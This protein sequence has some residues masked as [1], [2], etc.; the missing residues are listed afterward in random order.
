MKLSTFESLKLTPDDLRSKFEY[1][2]KTRRRPKDDKIKEFIELTRDRI[3]EGRRQNLS[4]FRMWWAM[5]TAYDVP[6]KQTTYSHVSTFVERVMNS[7]AQPSEILKMAKEWGIASFIKET[8]NDGKK[9]KPRVDLPVFF[10]IFIPLVRAY[11]H[12]RWAKLFNDRNVFPLLKFEPL[13]NTEVNRLR[14]EV[15]TDLI[16]AMGQ[17]LGYRSTLKQWI[18]NMLHYGTAI[19]FPVEDWYREYGVGDDLS[20]VVVKQ[21]L[22]YSIP[23]PSRVFY[24]QFHR[25]GTVNF[26]SGIQFGGYW[27]IVRYGEIKANESYWNRDWISMMDHDLI[28]SNGTFFSTVYPCQMSFPVDGKIGPRS[29]A[30]ELD[31]ESNASFYTSQHSDKGVVLCDLYQKL[32]PFQV[33][34]TSDERA[35]F[36][37]WFRTVVANDVDVVYMA[38]LGYSPLLYMGYDAHEE[39]RRNASLTLEVLPFQDHMSNLI[40]QQILTAKQ[41]LTRIVFVDENLVPRQYID[42]VANLGEDK[43]RSTILIPHKGRKT[44]MAQSDVRKAFEHIPFPV[45]STVE[46]MQAFRL[47][48]DTLERVLVFSAQEVGSVASHEQTAEETRIVQGSV[49]NRVALTDSFVDDAIYGWKKQ[50]FDADQCYND[51]TFEAQVDIVEPINAGVVED[52]GMK[53]ESAGRR[54]VTKA[55]VSGS[56]SKLAME[57]FVSAR[58]GENR[59]NNPE[60]AAGMSHIMQVMLNNQMTALAIGPR[61][62]IKVFNTIARLAGLPRDFALNVENQKVIDQM[63]GQGAQQ[64]GDQQ[65]VTQEQI[66][67]LFEQLASEIMKK[68]DADTEAKIKEQ[69]AQ[70]EETVSRN[71][72][73]VNNLGGALDQLMS[74]LDVLMGAAS[75][76]EPSSSPA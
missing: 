65:P 32:N 21:G 36:K 6:F 35:N 66:A 67:K 49:N 43:Y 11:L 12:I 3:R 51:D 24:D 41:N 57:K 68:V 58:E 26:D 1:S 22:R 47:L 10:Q 42:R 44:M 40:S 25:I 13:K 30:G 19:M 15:I 14:C 72:E 69:V 39:R 74:R 46:I 8:D 17:Q 9:C 62:A 73:E 23:H 33:G 31:R 20:K 27:R 2:P 76:R 56:R 50:L 28:R 18:F 34:L 53:I 37:T 59:I 5:D 64:S 16:E 4:D 52:A 70:V 55:Q 75:Q 7:D 38:P 60:L 63:M 71:A 61:Q 54:G 45:A 48:L 29:G